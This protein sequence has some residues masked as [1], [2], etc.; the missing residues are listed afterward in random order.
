MTAPLPLGLA[1]QIEALIAKPIQPTGRYTVSLP[2]AQLFRTHAIRE[3]LSLCAEAWGEDHSE[4]N[5]ELDACHAKIIEHLGT[6]T[7]R[8]RLIDGP[9]NTI[10][11]QSGTIS[12]QAAR[13]AELEAQLTASHNAA[14]ERAVGEC[15]KLLPATE[16]QRLFGNAMIQAIR[17]LMTKE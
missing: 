7:E 4:I 16:D 6:I 1:E 13:I 12:A 2:S 10:T 3:T 8:D 11:A 9:D 15:C 5:C 17:A 14:L